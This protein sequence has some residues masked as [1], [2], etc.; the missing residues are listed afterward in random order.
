MIVSKPLGNI[1]KDE[2]NVVRR[3]LA[4]LAS[5][6]GFVEATRHDEVDG[7]FFMMKNKLKKHFFY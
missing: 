4:A 7:E 5:K 3:A 6:E 2:S 1:L